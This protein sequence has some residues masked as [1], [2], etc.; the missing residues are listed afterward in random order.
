MTIDEYY[1]KYGSKI[2][3]D[4]ERLFVE[5]FLYPLIG[6][7]IEGV[8]PQYPFIDRTGRN[9]RI[10]FAYHGEKA[11]IAL[12]VNGETYHAEGI[13]ANE[14]FDDNLFRQ[15]E[16]LRSGYVLMRFSYSQLQSPQW[17][18][19][20][21]ETLRDTFRTY[22]PE[23]LTEYIL[24]P[25]TLQEEVLQA[26]NFY[27]NE[28]GW[29]K[30]IVV[31]PT[32]TGKT[33]LSALDSMNTSE[34]VLFMVHRLDILAQ[35]IEAYKFVNPTVR[36]GILTGDQRL[37]EQDCDVLFASKDTLRQP[38]EL[39]RFSQDWFDYIV[40]D[41][42]HHG[43]SPT[44]REILTYFTPGF[45]LGM[46]A[47]PD[48]TDRKDIFE[49]FDYN[50]VYEMPLAEAIERG[51]LV[52]YTY[53]GL[54][55]DVDYS[56]I[57]HDGKKYKTNDLERFLIIPERN[58]SILREYLDKGEGDKAIGFCVSIKH[59]ERMAEYFNQNEVSAAAIHSQSPTRD[60]DLKAFRENKIQVVF[61][62]DLFN[63]GMDFP[64][65]RI[66]LFLRPTE[67]KTV[68]IQQLGR[69]LR[70][71]AGK[72]RVR[73]LDFIGNYK[74][75]NQIRKYL[76]KGT[77]PGAEDGGRGKKL[78]YEYSNGCEVIFS[79]EVE[80]IL[81]RQ[82]AAE[83]G[84]S[85][86]ELKDAY[87]ALAETLGR[88]PSQTDLNASEYK[89]TVY[90]RIFGSWM[91]FLREIGE[92]TEAS[93]HY[94]QGT[95]LGHILSILKVFGSGNR[96]GSHLDDEF[97]RLR[98]GLGE[99]RLGTYQRQVKYKLQ[100]AMELGILP[101]D[102]NFAADEVY[103]LELTPLGRELYNAFHPMLNRLNLD[104]PREADGIPSTRMQ[105]NEEAYN[106][107]IREHIR[108]D[109]GARAVAYRIFLKMHA[110]QQMLAFLYHIIRTAEVDR[111]T[112][113]DQF[114][115]APFVKQFCDQ[116]GI[117]EATAE[118]AKRRCPFLLNI[119]AACDVIDARRSN[120]TIKRLLLL[121]SLVKPYQR[122]EAETTNARLR[123][124]AA[125]F[126]YAP[127][128]LNDEDLSIVKELFGGTFLT[129]DYYL[130][131]FEIAKE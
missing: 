80:E 90:I 42:V 94:P 4:S 82:D 72:D 114:F 98:G 64:N 44:Y 93:Y 59:A 47:T 89:A 9:R 43:Q 49:L 56:R 102:R 77:K 16:I 17:R 6:S 116:E 110:V 32:G 20:I 74:R 127:E 15:N 27:R 83:A 81:N 85:K 108:V 25:T 96:A 60:K 10:D 100:A 48:R 31:L 18:P 55:D 29:K 104:F 21:L 101:D 92:Y 63:E 117:D 99:N 105:D 38:S 67:S 70:L 124:V 118:A 113:Y 36:I 57:R 123:A 30:G 23:L 87:F 11:H 35:S 126:P 69:G 107:A 88:K 106:N 19:V 39:A 68:F 45:M 129:K 119:L 26:L 75:A 130:T 109:A 34:R 33:I 78:E 122:E 58:A 115:K 2:T 50:K 46:T 66:L 5:E 112:I 103:P 79:A 53:Y 128:Q 52:P 51:F 54:T 84:V 61:T 131:E 121:P 13:I 97:I 14:T 7:K 111:S 65:V 8:V 3:Q 12:E 125:A 91:K 1:K 40:V 28:R 76:S 86:E 62:V 120:I 37:N 24:A 71:C 41:E 95:H 22:A 73:V